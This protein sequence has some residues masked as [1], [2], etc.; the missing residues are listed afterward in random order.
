MGSDYYDILGLTKNCSKEDIKKHY[1]KMA[2]KWHP[3]RNKENKDIAE[4]KFK[5]LSEAYEVLSDDDNRQK[6]D[7]FGTI[8]VSGMT[9][10]NSSDIFTNLFGQGGGFPFNIARQNGNPLEQFR[11]F[12]GFN[13]N[14]VQQS[15]SRSVTMNNCG[16]RILRTETRTTNGNGVIQ[17]QVQEQIIG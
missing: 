8:D 17:V 13:A 10:Q 2:L 16:Q 15:T 11:M 7:K 6:Y 5:K 12:N 4:E 1:K 14:V 9:Y 3:D